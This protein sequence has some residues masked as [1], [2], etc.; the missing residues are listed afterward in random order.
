MDSIDEVGA[1]AERM[2]DA[3]WG[4]GWGVGRHVVLCSNYF[5]Y[6]QNPWGSLCEYSCDIDFVPA[7]LDWLADDHPPADSLYV[8]GPP[9]TEDFITNY[10][11][12][13]S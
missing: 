13:A 8:C 3:G 6:V 4:K 9:V 12:S 5:N 1:G 11:H 2:R 10:E 7:D